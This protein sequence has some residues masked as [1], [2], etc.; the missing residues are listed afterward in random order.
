[1]GRWAAGG[2]LLV[3]NKHGWGGVWT[4]VTLC[5]GGRG[6]DAAR[7]AAVGRD[8]RKRGRAGRRRRLGLP[9]S[10]D[11]ERGSPGVAGSSGL[12]R[13]GLAGQ[14]DYL[15]GSPEML[16]FCERSAE[17]LAVAVDLIAYQHPLRP[18]KVE[19][20]PTMALS[21]TVPS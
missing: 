14:G 20:M 9:C 7:V 10:Q 17:G 6:E 18:A 1:V 13:G 3:L 4:Q 16:S 21:T 2:S 8:W 19:L 12:K 15:W 5:G 11:R